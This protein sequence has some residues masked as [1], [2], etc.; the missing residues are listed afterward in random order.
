MTGP[1][2]STK[3]LL[4]TQQTVSLHKTS[5]MDPILMNVLFSV[6]KDNSCVLF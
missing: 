4:K 6:M 5:K 1:F 3:I 2:Y